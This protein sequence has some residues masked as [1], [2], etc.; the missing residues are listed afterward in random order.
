MVE[1]QLENNNTKELWQGMRTTTGY[2]PKNSRS[3]EGDVDSANTF[4]Q[5]HNRFDNVAFS[6]SAAAPPPPP[7]QLLPLYCF[8]CSSVLPPQWQLRALESHALSVT[9]T[10]FG[11]L[12]RTP[13]TH[14]ISHAE[15]KL[16]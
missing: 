5:Y 9:V 2:R 14:C 7:L 1:R 8:H 10:L 12:P 15:K 16:L 3:M 4:N 6:T 13:A 11:L